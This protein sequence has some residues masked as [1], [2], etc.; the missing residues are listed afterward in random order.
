MMSFVRASSGVYVYVTTS[1]EK[2]CCQ[3]CF[4]GCDIVHY[5]LHG[6][7]VRWHLVGLACYKVGAALAQCVDLC[8]CEFG[9]FGR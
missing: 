5:Y 6:L 7:S 3:S 9:A 8:G 2:H 1:V 4:L